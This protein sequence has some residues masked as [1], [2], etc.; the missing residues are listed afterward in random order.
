MFFKLKQQ[1][2]LMRIGRE[3]RNRKP[4]PKN[5][6]L[7]AS[8]FIGL[9]FVLDDEE[10][11]SSVL[12]LKKQLE[13]EGKRVKVIAYVPTREVPDYYMVQLQMDIF[14]KKAVNLLGVPTNEFARDFVKQQFDLLIDLSLTEHLPLYYVAGFGN[15][16]LRAGKYRPHLLSIYDF[17][18][19]AHDQMSFDDF[20][21][22]M[23]KYLA[24]LNTPKS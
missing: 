12:R 20:I 18:I 9:I 11:Y 7:S 10:K 14:S 17:M 1:F 23:M 5:T 16:T 6:S 24:L 13:A 3:Q 21:S 2:M 15:A 4:T 22:A 19:K 8:K